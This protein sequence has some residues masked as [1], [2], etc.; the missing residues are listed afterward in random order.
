[1]RNGNAKRIALGG[2]LAALAITIMCL[3]GMIPIATYI[4]PILCALLAKTVLTFCGRRIGWAWYG[5]VSFLGLI[6]GPDKEGALVFLLLGSYPFVKPWMDRQKLSL[7]WKLLFFNIGIA[8]IYLFLSK[9][10]GIDGIEEGAVAGGVIYGVLLVLGNIT[11][12]LLDR[13]LSF[14]LPQK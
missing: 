9:L 8:V 1:M 5:A 3:G 4:C 14:Q 11:F 12:F 7:L 13:I 10:I 2:M 6:I